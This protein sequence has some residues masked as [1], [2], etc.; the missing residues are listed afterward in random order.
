[1]NKVDLVGRL[2]KD[3]EIRYTQSSNTMV[4]SYT[5]AVKK[6]F[7]KE[8]EQDTD[9]INIVSWSKSAEFIQKYFHKGQQVWISGRIQTRS[10]EDDNGQ[11][12]YA[13]EVVTE[14]VG[15]ADSKKEEPTDV[16]NEVYEGTM[17][18]DGDELP[19]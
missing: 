9:F 16:T 13:T 8:G 10:W 2:T 6:R 4:A 14:E 17:V 3:P 15:F 7:A 1:M 11:K 19:F 5:L 12:H 18:T